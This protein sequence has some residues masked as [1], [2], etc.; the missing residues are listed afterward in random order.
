MDY[1]SILIAFISALGVVISAYIAKQQPTTPHV[2]KGVELIEKWDN[3]ITRAHDVAGAAISAL[4]GFSNGK[5]YYDGTH[6][7]VMNLLSYED[8][9][10]DHRDYLE[11]Q[12][13]PIR[14][15]L[16]YI[17]NLAPGQIA[18]FDEDESRNVLARNN[19]Q[20][21]IHTVA[22]FPVYARRRVFRWIRRERLIQVLIF[23]FP[24][25]NHRLTPEQ[26]TDIELIALSLSTIKIKE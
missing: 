20:D 10:A 3:L 18:Y 5:K 14:I 22:I 9:K 2:E 1:T 17:R 8:E 15:M 7:Q 16:R 13:I 19:V 12:N 24:G 21:G 23:K 4:W 6:A 25:K 11:L 26:V